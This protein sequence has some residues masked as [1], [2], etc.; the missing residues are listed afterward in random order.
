MS[1]RLRVGLVVSIVTVVVLVVG[2]LLFPGTGGTATDPATGLQ[3]GAPSP[4]AATPSGAG[5]PGATPP[6]TTVT[7]VAMG[8]RHDAA[9]A[10]AAAASFAEA[11]AT[12]VAL[13]EAGAVTAKRAM[14][15]T[16]T[17]DALVGEMRGRLA[18]LRRVW[19]VGAI[20]YRVAP[21]AVR[22]RMNG[23]DAATA[24]VW[25]VGVVAGRG[26]PTYEEWVT[27]TYG[28]VWERDDWRIATEAESPGPRPDPGR[29]SPASAGE[30]E[31]RL[32]GFE[33]I[34]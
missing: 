28:L 4:A 10:K 22:V 34:S 13:D 31:A 7:G 26:L 14:A 5:S 11:Y 12:L 27:Q 8:H 2:Q 15:S 9:G 24:D 6:A 21:L 20:T 25:Y 29:Q 3:N 30:L 33:A 1:R 23:P 18:A 16:A 17:A 19:P 32:A